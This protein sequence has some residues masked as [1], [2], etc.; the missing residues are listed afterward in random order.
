VASRHF[1][2]DAD[3]PPCVDARRGIARVCKA[4]VIEN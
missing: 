4:A 3:T 2:D 1:L